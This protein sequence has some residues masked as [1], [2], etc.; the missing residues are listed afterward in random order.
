MTNDELKS[1]SFSLLDLNLNT[2]LYSVSD[3]PTVALQTYDDDIVCKSVI[4]RCEATKQSSFLIP[5]NRDFV[6]IRLL[7]RHSSSAQ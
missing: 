2:K 4:G 3:N 1:Y 6:V 7:C 5:I